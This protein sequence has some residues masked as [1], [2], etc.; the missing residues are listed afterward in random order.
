[1]AIAN[2]RRAF[3][4]A[5]VV[6]PALPRPLGALAEAQFAELCTGC[7]DC[8][9][10]CP[11]GIIMRDGAELPVMDLNAGACTFCGACT[12][13]CETGALVPGQ[14]WLWR[15]RVDEACMS[16]QGIACRACEDHCDAQAIRFRLITGGRAEPRIETGLCTGCGACI[17]SCP[18]GAIT[19]HQNTQ[20]TEVRPC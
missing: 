7:G 2:S 13:A 1:M 16:R 18:T 8:A 6:R 20:D 14:A 4:T 15:A 19:L 10:I 5:K 11:E 9:R 17:A 3:L 12:E